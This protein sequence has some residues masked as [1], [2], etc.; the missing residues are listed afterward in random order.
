M[1]KSTESQSSGGTYEGSHEREMEGGTS[2]SA[3]V[4]L[5]ASTEC[6]RHRTTG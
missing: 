2:S 1:T 4:A 3:A 6:R 5:G